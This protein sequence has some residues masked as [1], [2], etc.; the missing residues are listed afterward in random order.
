MKDK[1]A[2]VF[3]FLMLLIFLDFGNQ[4]KKISYNSFF[5]NMQNPLF[6]IIHLNNTGSAFSLFQNQAT[7]LAYVGIIVTIIIAI[8]IYKN[9]AFNDKHALLS[10]TLFSAGTVGNSIERLTQGFVIDYIK[11]NFINFPIFNS[12]DIMI[13]LGIFL[14]AIFVLFDNK[15]VKNEKNSN[16]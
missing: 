12:Y 13:C 14:Y 15:K 3:Y 7:V 2:C 10:L 9:I 6:S 16:N 1:K 8:Y 11:L 5:E 4:L